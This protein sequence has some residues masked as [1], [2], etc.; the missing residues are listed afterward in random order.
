M[1]STS[2]AS[3]KPSA[4]NWGLDRWL[5]YFV[6]LV[7]IVTLG[8]LALFNLSRMEAIQDQL[9]RSQDTLAT[10]KDLS[11]LMS[12]AETGQRGYLL[13][14]SE[15][16]LEPYHHARYAIPE[17]LELLD[18]Q[19][20]DSF[21]AT[22]ELRELKKL[23]ESRLAEMKK[24]LDLLA[25]SGRDSALDHVNSDNGR[26]LMEQI[27][28][29]LQRLEQRR[30]LRVSD[31]RQQSESAY[32][33]AILT[34][35][36]AFLLT[37][38]S[39]AWGLLRVEGEL[40]RRNQAELLTSQRMRQLRVMTDIVSR[41]TAA[42]D[43]Y[44]VFGIALNEYRQLIGVREA[45]VR[46]GRGKSL[47]YEGSQ[48]S[49]AK[50]R[51]N[52]D[53]YRAAFKICDSIPC[54]DSAFYRTADQ[55]AEIPEVVALPEWQ[56]HHRQLKGM[57][58]VPMIASSR[59][60][61]GRL[62]LI[63]KYDS[64]FDDGDLS[65][66]MQLA[67]AVAVA[68]ENARLTEAA[69][70][71]AQRKDEFLAMLGHELRNP[72]AGILT[73]SETLSHPALSD[74]EYEEIR[75][76]IRRQSGAMND[77]VND[78]L[79]VSRI[80]RGKISLAPTQFDLVDA[81][82]DIVQDF[83]GADSQRSISLDI[84]APEFGLP[85]KADRTRVGQC[86]TNL[87]H[88]AC[89]FSPES[90]P[91]ELQVRVSPEDPNLAEINVTDHG[92]GLSS[93][94]LEDVFE[95]FHQVG[96]TIDRSAGGLGLGLPLARGIVE[97]HGGTLT[98][99]SDGPGMGSTF[100]LRLP[101]LKQEGALE[102]DG[103]D[104]I[105]SDQPVP[106][107]KILAIDDR[108]DARLPIKVL[109]TKEGH[110]VL[111]ADSAEQG[112]EVARS[113]QPDIII[114]DIGL[115]GDMNGYDVAR[116]L[117]QEPEFSSVYLVALSGY[118]QESDRRQAAAAGFDYHVAKPIAYEALNTLLTTRPRFSFTGGPTTEPATETPSSHSPSSGT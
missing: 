112:L 80:A 25:S 111:E 10:L 33:Q 24:T 92:V 100:C 29:V 31:L 68:V 41:I 57:L 45:I 90:T 85:V 107:L 58:T 94:E 99:L 87:L 47:R 53:F 81:I 71:A 18:N 74:E 6:P 93:K 26:E 59:G 103:S 72:L 77:I 32:F 84:G 109:L 106:Q 86:L 110:E 105:D 51:T 7:T 16:Y 42:R 19:M 4:P 101:L 75:A 102:T 83:S 70:V 46:I 35:V 9:V 98:A 79:D 64:D 38:A 95:L 66:S 39:I 43:V 69:N 5:L 61:I 34:A 117:R 78:L 67:H 89:K 12:E 54:D 88:N 11:A 63:H 3:S 49:S 23:T 76:M 36:I 48:P 52:D 13:T 30:V 118:S 28:S 114:C 113:E 14:E 104:P 40:T 50:P 20:A 37:L 15:S 22:D 27:T 73:G 91:V 116:T 1:K 8:G 17:S 44:S 55:L 21:E 62:L 60:K 2:D 65:I 108:A 96:T 115:P 82:Q 56:R 97:M